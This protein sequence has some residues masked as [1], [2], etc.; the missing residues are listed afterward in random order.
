MPVKKYDL[1]LLNPLTSANKKY[2]SSQRAS[3][4]LIRYVTGEG[5][6]SNSNHLLVLREEMRDRQKNWDDTNDARLKG[7]VG[8]LLGFYWHL[9]LCA[10]NTGTWLNIRCTAVTGTVMLAT[11]IR[12][13]LCAHYNVIPL[14]LQSN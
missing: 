9:I 5:K 1:G 11:E 2:L 12:D 3:T 14:N 8:D 10:K 6:F 4:E 7:L 13:F